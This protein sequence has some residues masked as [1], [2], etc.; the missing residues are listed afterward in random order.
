MKHLTVSFLGTLLLAAACSEPP[1]PG[2]CCMDE[3]IVMQ[4]DETSLWDGF[5]PP[6][7][8]YFPIDPGAYQPEFSVR[9]GELDFEVLACPGAWGTDPDPYEDAIDYDS[10]GWGEQ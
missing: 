1:E 10:E 4:C 7:G 8:H 6:F 9:I 3:D 5:A 2:E